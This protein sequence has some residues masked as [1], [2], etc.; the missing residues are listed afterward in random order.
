[1]NEIVAMLQ[2]AQR[3]SFWGQIQIDFHRG[4]V[5]LIRKTETFKPK[6]N[7]LHEQHKPT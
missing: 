2:K 3:E 6:E 1:M 7:T 4:E 5:T